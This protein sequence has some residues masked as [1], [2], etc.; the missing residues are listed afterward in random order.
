MVAFLNILKIKLLQI[1][2]VLKW[3]GEFIK[4]KTLRHPLKTSICVIFTYVNV[5]AGTNTRLYKIST[6]AGIVT[7]WIYFHTFSLYF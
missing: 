5:Y 2:F 7:S 4:Y 6:V 3:S 1:I